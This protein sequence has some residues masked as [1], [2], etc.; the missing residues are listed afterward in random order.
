L[1]SIL[2]IAIINVAA[3]W[4]LY[5]YYLKLYL[6]E[7]ISARQ[8]ITLEYVDKIIEKQTLAE[9]E[10]IFADAEIQFFELL[11]KNQWK[12]PLNKK[13][14]VDIVLNYLQKAWV[15]VKYMEEIIPQNNLQSILQEL[16]NTKSPESR[17]LHRLLSSIIIINV[18]AFLIM[19]VFLAIF[20]RIILY[21]IKQTTNSIKSL[22]IG[23]DFHMI[24]Y[25]KEDEIW[26]LVKAINELN[27]KLNIG[28]NIRNK[29]L[30]DISH[31]LK[32]P[33]TSIQ[34]YLEGIKDK[35]ISLDEKTLDSIISEM[36]RLVKL[37]NTIMEYEKYE[38]SEI[39]MHYSMED[40][41]YVTEQVV[42]QFKQ[43][44]KNNNQKVVTLGLKRKI[45]ID[46]DRFIQIIQNILSNFIKY[47][48]EN[49]Q[50]KIEFGVNSIT[51]KDNGKGLSKEEI[52]YIKEKFYQWKNEKTWDINDRGI[53]VGFSIIEKILKAMRWKMRIESEEGQWFEIKIIT[54]NSQ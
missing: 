23:K 10:N 11:E 45:S 4:V 49:T 46:K 29:L 35:V 34:C 31:E 44:F 40:I 33:I 41:R 39:E 24:P 3:F 28:D 36:Q 25:Y 43:K 42:K 19:I 50:L 27:T 47:A 30:A 22:Y 16:Q 53:W 6:S 1:W 5:T 2:F 7:K 12:I 52:P 48:G 8:E 54:K 26:L 14:N 13:E 32:T 37:V 20:I 18:I 51:F 9:V 38:S 17:F 21:P 15:S